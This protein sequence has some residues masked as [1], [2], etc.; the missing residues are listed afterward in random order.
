MEKER[1]IRVPTTGVVDF[2]SLI[3][4]ETKKYVDK[5]DLLYELAR[6]KTDSQFFI[7]RPRRFGKSLMLST[8]KA[9]FE[10]RR[11]FFKGLAIDK[12]P[13]EGWEKPTPVYSFTMANAT[14]A[15]YDLFLEQL[16]K[17]VRG[18]CAEAD[19]PYCEQGYVPGQFEDFLKAAAAKSPTK[20]I[21][22]LID[23]YDE[24]VAKFLDDIAT[25]LGYTPAELYQ[26]GYLTISEV[27]DDSMF[28][29]GIPNNE[30]SNSLS[31]G[32]V[33]T[34]LDA[35]MSDWN[36]SLAEARSGLRAKGVETPFSGTRAAST[37]SSSSTAGRRRRRLGRPAPT[38]TRA[39]GSTAPSPCSTWAST[40]TP[41]A[42]ASTTRS[43]SRRDIYVISA[44]GSR[45]E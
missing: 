18:L 35:G 12:L 32:Y 22:V 8:L 24:P 17:L 19:V 9:M 31:E 26:G 14:A 10:G 4:D 36:E 34:I 1:V 3:T 13:W 21:V 27:I 38:S 20:Q 40:T 41:S 11:D 42:A 28:R 45:G 7:S 16:A 39:P 44:D 5:T 15:A 37:S 2:E 43:S 30:I 6:P 23:E 25:L 33:S 29:L